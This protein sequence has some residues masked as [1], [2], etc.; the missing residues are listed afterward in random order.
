MYCG[1]C[2]MSCWSLS[3]WSNDDVIVSFDAVFSAA[4]VWVSQCS[5]KAAHKHSHLMIYFMYCNRYCTNFSV[6]S[7]KFSHLCNGLSH[8]ESLMRPLLFTWFG[9]LCIFAG[10]HVWS[11]AHV[12]CT[13]SE[14]SRWLASSM[15]SIACNCMQ[16]GLLLPQNNAGVPRAVQGVQCVMAP[17]GSKKLLG[18]IHQCLQFTK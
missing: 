2:S 3:C 8:M 1:A 9:V 4:I 10:L 14:E 15:P 6:S 18:A 16:K 13:L 11:F 7:C 17:F 12:C 5:K